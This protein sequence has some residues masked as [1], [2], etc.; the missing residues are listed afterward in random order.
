[1]NQEDAVA[2][3][4]QD[5]EL[6]ETEA[7]GFPENREL[8][9]QQI[10]Q[11]AD[12]RHVAGKKKGADQNTTQKRIKKLLFF[13]NSSKDTDEGEEGEN[14]GA[15]FK[16]WF[17]NM[18][19]PGFHD[20][21]VVLT[22]DQFDGVKDKTFKGDK[23]L[24]IASAL[25]FQINILAGHLINFGLSD[26]SSVENGG[27]DIGKAPEGI[28]TENSRDNYQES[29][30]NKRLFV[31]QEEKK[32]EKDRNKINQENGGDM[33]LGDREER[34]SSKPDKILFRASFKVI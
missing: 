2:Q 28:K 1:M 12:D 8:C 20:V 24:K 27:V 15:D 9:S 22:V 3:T 18:L 33:G 10:I 29:F 34:Q 6:S 16:D 25:V 19:T 26:D 5:D 11:G 31:N 30:N 4:K 23:I 7:E 14:D 17:L 21:V 32:N 13:N